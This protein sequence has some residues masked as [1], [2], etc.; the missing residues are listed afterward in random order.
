M[1]L[2]LRLS[3]DLFDRI[4]NIFLVIKDV[5]DANVF[6]GMLIFSVACLEANQCQRQHYS[7]N[8]N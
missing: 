4:L 7:F 2:K 5:L 3:L 6:A 8:F 1:W